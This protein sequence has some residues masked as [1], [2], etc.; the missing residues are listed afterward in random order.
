MVLAL[1]VYDITNQD[2]V[3]RNPVI[4]V[5]VVQ[6]WIARDQPDHEVVPCSTSRGPHINGSEKPHPVVLTPTRG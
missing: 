3:G 1:Y 6:T 5:S 2:I 4:R